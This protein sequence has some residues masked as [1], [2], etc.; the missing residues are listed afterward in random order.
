MISPSSAPVVWEA[1]FVSVE[2]GDGA[3][4]ATDSLAFTT[5]GVPRAGVEVSVAVFVIGVPAFTS[6]CVIV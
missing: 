5:G 2:F 1:V 6:S 3:I 4:T